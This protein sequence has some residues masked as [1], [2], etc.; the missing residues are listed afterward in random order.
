MLKP[1]GGTRLIALLNTLLRVWGRVRR[2]LRAVWERSQAHP[3]F[4]GTGAGRSSSDCA[5]HLTLNAEVAHAR[6]QHVI[7]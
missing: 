2:P 3:S 4:W 1:T 7:T 6:R 5:C